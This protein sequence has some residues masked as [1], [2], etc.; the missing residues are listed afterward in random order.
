VRRV[1]V[2]ERKDHTLTVR[3]YLS[4]AAVEKSV[5]DKLVHMPE[6]GATG[7]KLEVMVPR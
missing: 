5:T 2:E 4:T 6:L 3:V 1:E 7:V